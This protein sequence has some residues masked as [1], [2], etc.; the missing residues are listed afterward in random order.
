M[1]AKKST[2]IRGG[3]LYDLLLDRLV[4]NEDLRKRKPRYFTIDGSEIMCH[5]KED[6]T[7]LADFLETVCGFN[8]HVGFYDPKDN[9]ENG[10]ADICTEKWC[11]YAD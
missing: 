11:V 4:E 7:A 1:Q 2:A 5:S 10:E 8:I 6:A 3:D 9:E